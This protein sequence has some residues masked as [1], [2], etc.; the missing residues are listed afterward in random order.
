M[1]FIEKQSTP[2]NADNMIRLP[3]SFP[4]LPTDLL[5]RFPESA[6]QWAEDI[7]RW[8]RAAV[9]G[10]N[11]FSR[12]VTDM[13]NLT[14]SG[15]INAATG[16]IGGFVIGPDYIRDI[17]NSMGLA[18][19]QTGADD[20][21]FWAGTTFAN[22]ANAPFVVFESG[23][24]NFSVSNPINRTRLPDAVAQ[25]TGSSGTGP[26]IS[27]ETEDSAGQFVFR[28]GNS[29]AAV[30][31]VGVLANDNLGFLSWRGNDTTGFTSSRARVQ[32]TATENWAAGANGTSIDI[33]T[34][35]IGTSI[36]SFVASFSGDG[37]LFDLGSG[38]LPAVSQIPTVLRFA[39]ADNKSVVVEGISFTTAVSGA[40]S[41]IGRVIGGTRA[42]PAA[43]PAFATFISLIAKGHDG[44]GYVASTSGRYDIYG[45]SLWSGANRE[46]NHQWSGTPAGSTIVATWMSLVGGILN[47]VDSI[48]SAKIT[49]STSANSAKLSVFRNT[50]N[51]TGASFNLQ[52]G[53][54]T[55]AAAGQIFITS[56]G[57]TGGYGGAESL[58]L[59][60]NNGVIAFFPSNT[61]V[62]RVHSVN[63]LVMAAGLPLQ[64][65]NAYVAGLAVQTGT[66]KITD[67]TGTVYRFLCLV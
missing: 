28:R 54:D 32:S 61:E 17:A 44:A 2:V 52:F 16:N 37:H 7:Q 38:V 62:F 26:I 43:T 42:A 66:V 41:L 63:G 9:N 65:G 40:T 30:G 1:P 6:P 58:N 34:T 35:A 18:S 53:N 21:R 48:T 24:V 49:I 4:D 12:S 67:S 50:N 23:K 27:I 14:L 29:V 36:I 55:T 25:F 56:S 45:G 20:V 3:G 33:F 8:W 57:W 31:T 11:D 59:I 64:L 5:D 60:T 39:T 15:S 46:T 22:R 47:V 13:T 10:L 19:S 51:G